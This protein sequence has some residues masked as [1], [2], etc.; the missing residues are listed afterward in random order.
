MVVRVKSFCFFFVFKPCHKFV[1]CTYDCIE[2]VC[3]MI[4]NARRVG[5]AKLKREER[6]A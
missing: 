5:G 3:N 2:C 1:L 4:E 6:E